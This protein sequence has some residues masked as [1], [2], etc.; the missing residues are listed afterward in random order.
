[1]IDH[2]AEPSDL[3]VFLETDPQLFSLPVPSGPG[4]LAG[5]VLRRR[6]GSCAEWL[7]A[8]RLELRAELA[9]ELT[10][11]VV[12]NLLW[13][14]KLHNPCL[15]DAHQHHLGMLDATGATRW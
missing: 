5:G 15:H 10:A 8:K 6:D 1:M 9:V 12:E 2:R 3:V 13:N 7:D 11:V 4:S 14:P